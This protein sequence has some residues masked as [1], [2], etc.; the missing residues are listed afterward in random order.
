MSDKEELKEDDF[1]LVNRVLTKVSEIDT[2]LKDEPE[3]VIMNVLTN[4]LIKYI[5][6]Y[7]VPIE[8]VVGEIASC[9]NYNVNKI[10]EAN[11]NEVKH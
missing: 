6:L 10:N 9:Y 11:K 4:M 5:L 1:S 3:E 8:L 2:V 7:Q